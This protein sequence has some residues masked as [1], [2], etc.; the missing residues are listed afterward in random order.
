MQP[1]LDLKGK[2]EGFGWKSVQESEVGMGTRA[3]RSRAPRGCFE[4]EKSGCWTLQQSQIHS[5]SE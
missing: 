1:V 4:E 2:R 5:S 3:G